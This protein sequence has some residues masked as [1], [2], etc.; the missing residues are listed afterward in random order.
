MLGH[1]RQRIASS[2]SPPVPPFFP[3]PCSKRRSANLVAL[4]GVGMSV[5][6]ISH[7]SKTFEAHSRQDRAGH[8][9]ARQRARELQGA[10]PAGRRVA[11]VLDGAAQPADRRRHR[12]LHRD[13]R[14]GAEGGQGSAARR[15]R[16]HRRVDRERELQPH[17]APG[18]AEADAKRRLRP[19]DDEQHVV[20][21]RVDRRAGSRRCAAR[22]RHL[23]RHVQ[24]PDRRVEVR[25]DLR[26]RAEEPRP[27][28]RDAGDRSRRSAAALAEVAAHDAELRGARRERL[29]VQHAAVLRHLPDGPGDEVGAVARAAS[30]R[31]ASTTSARPRSSMRRSIAAAS[32]AAPPR[33]AAARA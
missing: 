6:E 16:E 11:A 2:I 31:S 33:R 3:F 24:P 20:R 25:T 21:H 7:R 14:L 22:R 19:H 28:R 13:R 12:R 29:D 4:P 1:I 32:I 8:P 17:P 23:V 5:L 18:R 10:V 15:H 30:T 27:V 9:R 26:R